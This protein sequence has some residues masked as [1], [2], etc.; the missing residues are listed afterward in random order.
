MTEEQKAWRYLSVLPAG[1][2]QATALS[3]RKA[4]LD[5]LLDKLEQE[6]LRRQREYNRT[7]LHARLIRAK[8]EP[9][10]MAEW[11]KNGWIVRKVARVYRR[12]KRAVLG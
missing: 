1:G 4:E 10:V 6:Q 5:E 9:S 7:S 8:V 2:Y 12:R 11:K 3:E